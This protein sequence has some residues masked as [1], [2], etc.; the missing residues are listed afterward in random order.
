[1]HHETL[2]S[3]TLKSGERLRNAAT[4]TKPANATAAITVTVDS[5]FVRSCRDGEPHFEVR[6][7]CRATAA[8]I[9]RSRRDRHR[10]RRPDPAKPGRRWPNGRDRG[11]RIHRRISRIAWAT[12][13]DSDA[14]AATATRAKL[15]A[16]W[17]DQ[18]ILVVGTHY[19]APTAGYVKRDRAAFRFEV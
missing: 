19:A 12:S 5:T 8:G 15:F 9:W 11:D 7:D 1:M 3:H 18:P 14:Q 13:F 17:A 6:R 4:E 16:E 10:Y 2:R